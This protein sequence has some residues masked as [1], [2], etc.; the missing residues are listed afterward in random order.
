VNNEI[1]LPHLRTAVGASIAVHAVFR[2]GIQ[3]SAERCRA[4]PGRLRLFRD[5]YVLDRA[6][7]GD[8]A[9]PAAWTC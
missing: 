2:N 7:R 8:H 9:G 4:A 6:D 3:Q 1:G 5:F